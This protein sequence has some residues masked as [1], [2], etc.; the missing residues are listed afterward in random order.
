MQNFKCAVTTLGEQSLEVG[1]VLILR[2]L[3][4]AIELK[5]QQCSMISWLSY[6]LILLKLADSG[7]SLLL[8]LA[9]FQ[10][11]ILKLAAFDD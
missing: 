6:E 3:Q 2:I 10:V 11:L 1:V 5:Q 8:M 4:P 9:A 7:D